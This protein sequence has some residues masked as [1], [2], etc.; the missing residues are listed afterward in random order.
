[1][2]NSA[3]LSLLADHISKTQITTDD[4]DE[5]SVN[6]GIV[7]LRALR[8]TLVDS[9]QGWTGLWHDFQWS[10]LLSLGKSLR[11][12]CDKRVAGIWWDQLR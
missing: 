6:I 12:L 11:D 7:S 8:K 10:V 4:D 1:M 2:S 3:D 9:D 5:N